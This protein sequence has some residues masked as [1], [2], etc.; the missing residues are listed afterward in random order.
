MKLITRSTEETYALATSVAKELNG[1]EVILLNGNL[2]AG[3]TT[4]TKGLALAL[5]VQKTVVS[6]TFT[7][8][9]EYKGDKLHLYHI[10]MYRLEDDDELEELGVD[11]L[12]RDDSVVVIEWNRATVLPKKVIK[13]DI[14]VIDPTTRGWEVQGI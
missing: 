4:F 11:E 3:K 5:G 8:I 10:D 9:K 13:I 14:E 7:I 2:G 1:G 12:F 6:P